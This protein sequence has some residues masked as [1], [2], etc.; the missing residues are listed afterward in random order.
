MT[1]RVILPGGDA[2]KYMRF[3]DAYVKRNDGTL[4][5]T[6]TGAASLTYAVGEW[7]DVEGDECTSR[8]RRFFRR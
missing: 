6:R 3:G 4:D 2:D 1:V 8:R 5:V 7:A